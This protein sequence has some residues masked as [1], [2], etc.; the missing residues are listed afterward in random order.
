VTKQAG[1]EAKRADQL[2]KPGLVTQQIIDLA[3]TAPLVVADLTDVNPNV[4]YE[5]AIRHMVKKPIVLVIEHDQELPFDVAM[6]RTIFVNTS[7]WDSLAESKRE[8]KAQI[9]SALEKG[10]VDNPIS[11]TFELKAVR[12]TG[13]DTQKL[14]ANVV[15]RL[16]TVSRR[17][18]RIEHNAD[19]RIGSWRTQREIR[20]H[21]SPIGEEGSVGEI[22]VVDPNTG[23]RRRM[24]D[25]DVLPNWRQD[26]R[27]MSV[28]NRGDEPTTVD[29]LQA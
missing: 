13:D 5:L 9:K 24:G 4:M 8:L 19:T 10:E 26:L 21:G 6:N 14:L 7:D 3:A 20:A 12:E 28:E 17:M 22:W 27:T 18:G 1:F 16:D 23:E 15:E 29:G 2:E 25:I 11:Q